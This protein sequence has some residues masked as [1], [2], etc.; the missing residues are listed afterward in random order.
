MTDPVITPEIDGLID[1]IESAGAS[2]YILG[3]SRVVD[4][5]VVF[6]LPRPPLVSERLRW[7]M[8]MFQKEFASGAETRKA[9][10]EYAIGV[11]A[12]YVELGNE[13]PVVG[14]GSTVQ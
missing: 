8:E 2:W 12:Y 11:G 7:A 9:V 3:G 14:D 5:S 6:E 1:I 4:P 10:I 13:R